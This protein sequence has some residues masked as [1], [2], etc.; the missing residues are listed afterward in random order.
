VKYPITLKDFEGQTIEVQPAGM[1]SGPKLLVNGQPAA[2]G[3]KRGHMILQDNYGQEVVA[4]WRPR[5]MG[6][7][8]P[9]L[10][11]DGEIVDVTKPLP[12]YAWLWRGLP[13]VLAFAG[14][15]LGFLTG[16]IAFAVNASI[17][18]SGKSMALK[19]V[20]TA[21]VSLLAVVVYFVLAVLLTMLLGQV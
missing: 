21:G 2:K 10:V 6:L 3:S 19:F 5:F 17:F 1:L 7:D 15:A 13:I 18:R 20:L 9:Q 4:A 14:G 8:V 11:V 16:I 12:W